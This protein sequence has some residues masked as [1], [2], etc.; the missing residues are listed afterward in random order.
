MKFV[1][2]TSRRSVSRICRNGIRQGN[3]LRGRGVYAVPLVTLPQYAAEF[4]ECHRYDD[5]CSSLKCGD[6][7]VS[8][9]WKSHLF[10]GR[11]NPRGN[12]FAS[13]VFELSAEHWP[14]MMFASW[15]QEAYEAL[16]LDQPEDTKKLWNLLDASKPPGKG[17]KIGWN[18][19]ELGFLVKSPHGL[20]SLL[21]R[22]RESGQILAAFGDDWLEIVV[23]SSIPASNIRRVVAH[24]ERS[25][26]GRQRGRDER[27]RLEEHD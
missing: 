23:S 20:G 10:K 12:E 17:R 5:S 2:L 9:L 24:Y 8:K 16:Q 21:H 25:R 11:R 14:I 27:S 1:H 3:G 15:P 4:V 19:N 6:L 26:E 7:S 22:F 18:Y 13:I